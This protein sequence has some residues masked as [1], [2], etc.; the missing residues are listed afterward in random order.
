MKSTAFILLVICCVGCSS[1]SRQ[2]G[3]KLIGNISL[4]AVASKYDQS[5]QLVLQNDHSVGLLLNDYVVET[6]GNDSIL[7]AK[8]IGQKGDF[9]YFKIMHFS[10]YQ[11]ASSQAILV[12]EYDQIRD[13]SFITFNFTDD[14]RYNWK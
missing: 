7:I 14:V 5:Y 8:C 9:N 2:P 12:A 11:P 1:F 13:S 6:F 3:I 10:G 4:V